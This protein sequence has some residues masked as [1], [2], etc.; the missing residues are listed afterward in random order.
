MQLPS[1][2]PL[3]DQAHTYAALDLGSNSFHLLVARVV[4]HHWQVLDTLKHTVRLAEGVRSDGTLDS[5]VKTRAL[6]SLRHMA[7][8]LQGVPKRNTRVVGTKALR[9]AGK[10]TNFLHQAKT[11]LGVPVEVIAGREEARLLYHGVVHS[12]PPLK[13]NRLVMDI[14]GGSTELII[15]RQHRIAERESLN[16]GCVSFTRRFFACA[17]SLREFKKA[18]HAATLEALLLLRPHRSTLVRHGW[19][20]VVGASGTFR[21]V[22]RVLTANGWSHTGITKEG[23]DVLT[24]TLLTRGPD[25][26]SQL[27]GLSDSRRPVFSAGL[28][29]VRALFDS[30]DLKQVYLAQGA[31]REGLI[32][33]LS[34]WTGG[35][36]VRDSSVESLA[37]RFSVD[38]QQVR[39]VQA[40]VDGLVSRAAPDFKLKKRHR[41]ALKWVICLHE[42]GLSVAHSGF[43]RH[44]AYLVEHADLPGFSRT[45]Q[46]WL[47]FLIRAQKGRLDPGSST[48]TRQGLWAA[49]LPLLRC[50]LAVCRSRHDDYGSFLQAVHQVQWNETDKVLQVTVSGH[51]LQENPLIT[52][53]LRKSV[54]QLA[55]QELTGKLQLDAV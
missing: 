29:I 54:R 39:R 27:K 18:W 33:D 36:D 35:R 1:S 8:R 5:T 34:G 55:D 52:A 4:N 3:H 9:A 31:L 48:K 28:A 53:D 24:S 13:K 17:D 26:L 30:L 37:M 11:I 46:A 45:E 2:H 7:Q 20:Q 38:Q 21:A 23:L 50:A 44:G 14:G 32:L 40:V 42:S 22:E 16:M 41:A 12:L 19:K 6:N 25:A 15:G 43:N 51:W 49:Q 47:A 10:D